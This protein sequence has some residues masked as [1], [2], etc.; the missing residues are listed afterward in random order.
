MLGYLLISLLFVVR[1]LLRSTTSARRRRCLLHPIWRYT[2]V[3]WNL[4]WQTILLLVITQSRFERCICRCGQRNVSPRRTVSSVHRS[5]AYISVHRSELFRVWLRN[6]LERN[7]CH[8]SVLSSSH[9]R[10]HRR[11]SM[12]SW[13]RFLHAF[14]CRL[15]GNTKKHVWL[16][17]GPLIVYVVL[18]SI[19]YNIN[20]GGKRAGALLRDTH[21]WTILRL[22]LICLFS[23][24]NFILAPDGFREDRKPMSTK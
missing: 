21:C 17:A 22:P 20:D 13:S 8:P 16:Y 6:L 1:A 18:I 9:H 12:R 19:L 10:V 11:C 24:R 15:A 4:G 14:D 5:D 3:R 7:C 2:S 23:T